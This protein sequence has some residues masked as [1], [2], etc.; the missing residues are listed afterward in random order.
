MVLLLYRLYRTKEGLINNVVVKCSKWLH[1]WPTCIFTCL[2]TLPTTYG[3]AATEKLCSLE[4]GVLVMFYCTH[5]VAGG[6]H[7]GRI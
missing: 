5:M 4:V 2:H 6:L 3:W 1:A 7:S